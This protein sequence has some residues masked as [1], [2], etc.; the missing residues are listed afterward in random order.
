VNPFGP[1]VKISVNAYVLSAEDRRETDIR[2]IIRMSHAGHNFPA[3]M[4]K[5]LIRRL[6]EERSGEAKARRERNGQPRESSD[7]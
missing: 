1:E 4:V 7:G 3:E 2:E 6:D 5:F